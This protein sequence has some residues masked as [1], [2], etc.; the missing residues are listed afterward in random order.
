MSKVYI[1]NNCCT[2]GNS[3]DVETKITNQRFLNN[4]L[5]NNNL[6]FLP[7]KVD[8]KQSA[9]IPY[10]QLLGQSA[11]KTTKTSVF[12]YSI[13]RYLGF[14]LVLFLSGKTVSVKL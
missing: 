7:T 2:A 4:N 9:S 11:S 1:N 14:Y 10:F 12:Q 13:L 6:L 8:F 3:L 5:L